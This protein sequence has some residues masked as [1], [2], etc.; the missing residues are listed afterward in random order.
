MPATA[1]TEILDSQQLIAYHKVVTAKGGLVWM[2][3]GTGK[4]RVGILGSIELAE[5]K[6]AIPVILRREAFY[7]FQQ[8]IAALQLDVDVIEMEQ[9]PLNY[10]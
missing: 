4:T 3:V 1:V 7:D 5:R 8:E 2:A 6:P 10:A 9:L